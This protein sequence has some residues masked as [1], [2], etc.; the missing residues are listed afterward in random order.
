MTSWKRIQMRRLLR[1]ECGWL[2]AECQEEPVE[3]NDAPVLREFN[4]YT[5]ICPTHIC[6][7]HGMR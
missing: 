5:N 6:A 1:Y 3:V 7:L 2:A 4:E